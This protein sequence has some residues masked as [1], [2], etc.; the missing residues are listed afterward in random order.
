MRYVKFAIRITFLIA[1]S[2]PLAA[3]MIVIWAF[4]MVDMDEMVSDLR[5][6]VT[7]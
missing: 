2:L 1:L 5:K 3:A 4:N 7:L 6:A